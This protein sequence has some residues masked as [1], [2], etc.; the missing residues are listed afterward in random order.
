MRSPKRTKQKEAGEEVEGDKEG[1]E[2]QRNVADGVFTV[3][4]M[5]K[6]QAN[7]V[8]DAEDEIKKAFRTLALETHPDTSSTSNVRDTKLKE[9]RFG[10]LYEAYEV[11]STPKLRRNYDRMMFGTAPKTAHAG[12]RGSGRTSVAVLQAALSRSATEDGQDNDFKI[13]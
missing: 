13:F 8:S 7:N 12:R 2:L 11:L 5:R 10:Y 1:T 3:D 9:E 6:L 4:S